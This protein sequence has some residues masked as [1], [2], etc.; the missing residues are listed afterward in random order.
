MRYR[1]NAP[2]GL[3][4]GLYSTILPTL[5]GRVKSFVINSLVAHTGNWEILALSPVVASVPNSSTEF[6]RTVRVP[7]VL[8]VSAGHPIKHDR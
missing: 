3:P 1:S 4:H 6:D 8:T 2:V 5:V 7:G